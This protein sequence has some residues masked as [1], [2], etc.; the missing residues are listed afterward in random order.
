MGY[1]EDQRDIQSNFSQLSG[2]Q[3]RGIYRKVPYDFV[4]KDAKD[5]LYGSIAN[6]AITYFSDNNIGWWGG[7][8]LPT[9]HMLSSQVAC[10]NHLFWLMKNKAAATQVLQTIDPEFRA[11]PFPKSAAS[12]GDHYVEFEYIT[13]KQ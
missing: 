7:K 1:S 6:P 2:I 5:N 12:P 3:N 8:G 10:V 11:L 9:N 4:L 13:E